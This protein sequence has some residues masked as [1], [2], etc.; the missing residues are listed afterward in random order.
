MGSVVSAALEA[1][2]STTAALVYDYLR[3]SRDMLLAPITATQATQLLSALRDKPD[4][5]VEVISMLQQGTLG[6][7]AN[8]QHYAVALQALVDAPHEAKRVFELALKHKMVCQL[9]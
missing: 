7:R 5:V 6:V 8:P 4:K 9:P 1:R 3:A 2:D